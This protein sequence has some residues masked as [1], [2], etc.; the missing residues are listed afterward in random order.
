MT[1][2]KTFF[3]KL[4]PKVI[5]YRNYKNFSNHSF[6]SGLISKISSNGLLE[7]DLTGSLVA[8]KKPLDYQAPHKKKYTRVNEAPFL[9]NEINKEIMTKWKLRNKFL[10]YRSDEIKKPDNEQLNRYVKLEVPEKLIIAIV[11]LMALM[12]IKTLENS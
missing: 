12:T 6:C 1:V 4:S 2:L 3:K 5:S 11:A 8:C 9:T 7:R 10:R